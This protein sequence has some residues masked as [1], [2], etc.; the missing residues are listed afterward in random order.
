MLIIP[1][2]KAKVRFYLTEEGGLKH[3]FPR[4]CSERFGCP[5]SF[6]DELF[7]CWIMLCIMQ[8]DILLRKWTTV[9]RQIHS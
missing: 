7:D 4:K 9:A 1:D 5:F 8:K 3:D 2:I 6:Q